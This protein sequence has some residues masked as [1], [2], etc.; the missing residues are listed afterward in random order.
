M[1][2]NLAGIS[3]RP[4]QTLREVMLVIDKNAKG[5]ALVV[6]PERRLLG[7]ISDGDMRRAMLAAIDFETPVS[8][9]LARKVGTQYPKPVTAKV[10]VGCDELL[11]LMRKHVLRQVPIL[12]DD[13]RVVDLAVLDDLVSLNEL[14]LQAV[15]MA[16]GLGTRLRPLTEDLPK[17][18]LLV[19]GKP[20]M[21]RVIEQLRQVGIR[22]VNVTTNYMP[23]KI[24]EHFGDG[25]GFGV[26]L[27]Y[28]NEDRPLGTG[29]ALGLMPVPQEPVLVINGDI[30]T[31][32]NFRAMLEFHREQKTDLTVAVR[33]YEMQVPYGVIECEGTLV[34]RLQEKP[35]VGFLVNAGIYLLEPSAYQFIPQNTSFNMTDLIQWLLDAGRPVV[36]FPIHEYWLDIGQH[37]DYKQAQ[38]D[39]K[40]G[41]FSE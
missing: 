15:I 30:L 9:L 1:I 36:S 27:N 31:Q 2:I 29:G 12:D 13:G 19:D 20:L 26:E 6:D 28:V 39:V 14:S 17:P 41:R 33:R 5:I 23:E 24:V 35:Q 7:T 25:R 18:M 34:R 16:G 38:C 11:A 8:A 10:G 32:V 40:N 4:E 37:A 3:V 21:E 22:R